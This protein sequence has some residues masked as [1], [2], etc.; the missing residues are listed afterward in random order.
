MWK[1][2]LVFIWNSNT[3]R[4]PT[5]LFVKSSNPD[6]P[7]HQNNL[8][9]DP[10]NCLESQK[11]RSSGSPH[12]LCTPQN[13]VTTPPPP[14]F[15]GRIQCLRSG[16]SV[17]HESFPAGR[18]LRTRFHHDCSIT[19]PPREEGCSSGSTARSWGF[20]TQMIAFLKPPYF[21]YPNCYVSSHLRI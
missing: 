19:K 15:P 12:P 3:P 2:Y 1:M 20:C 11:K 4:H 18:G 9:R 16:E 7:V 6:H 17:F 8:E 13:A 5:F 14:P 21:I 10:K